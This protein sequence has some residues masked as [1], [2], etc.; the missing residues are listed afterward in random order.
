MLNDGRRYN[1]LLPF[2][3]CLFLCAQISAQSANNGDGLLL[4]GTVSDLEVSRSTSAV[5]FTV[6]L[7]LE[8]RNE[9]LRPIIL[10]RPEPMLGRYWQGGWRI[11]AE[12]TKELAGSGGHW[13]SV[14]GSPDYLEL[15]K[16]LDAKNP[17]PELTKILAPGD[18][19]QFDDDCE[20]SF[21]YSRDAF[22]DN[23]TWAELQKYPSALWLSVYYELNPWN[24][25]FRKFKPHL[26][27]NLKKRWKAFGEVL[28]DDN[29]GQFDNFNIA[30]EAIAIDLSKA[31]ERSA[32]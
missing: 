6:R 4:L 27:R 5:A 28:I 8:L 30:S 21:S 32:S 1:Y 26:I 29:A 19:W 25:E 23:V 22:S 10:F 24:V 20:L 14:S 2:F 7:K 15:G 11:F 3:L 9:S 18:N 16:K 31:R 17:P 13:Q 12:P